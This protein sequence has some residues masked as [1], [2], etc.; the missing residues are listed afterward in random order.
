MAG[1]RRCAAILP[2]Q[3]YETD[4]TFTEGPG[5]ALPMD[6]TRIFDVHGRERDFRWAAGPV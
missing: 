1:F 6:L 3:T 4:I 5:G 2:Q